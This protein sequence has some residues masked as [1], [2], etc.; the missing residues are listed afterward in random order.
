MKYIYYVLILG[1]IL[2]LNSCTKEPDIDTIKGDL[3]GKHLSIKDCED[4]RDR[5]WT[6][7]SLSDIEAFVVLDKKRKGDILEFN[8]KLTIKHS[9]ISANILY[10]KESGKWKL[11]LIQSKANDF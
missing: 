1:S 4:C 6:F 3:I 9:L 8:T 2:I 7:S 5:G 10:R 11:I